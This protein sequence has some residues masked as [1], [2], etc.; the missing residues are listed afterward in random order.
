MHFFFFS[1]KILNCI[2]L[3]KLQVLCSVSTN[4][5]DSFERGQWRARHLSS[6]SKLQGLS[7]K[8]GLKVDVRA[9]LSES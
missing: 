2:S 9:A 3:I 8:K 7:F 6:V 5:L 4:E 1:E